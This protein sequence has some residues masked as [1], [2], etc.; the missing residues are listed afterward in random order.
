MIKLRR[1]S[2]LIFGSFLVWSNAYA[3]SSVLNLL[4]ITPSAESV[5]YVNNKKQFHLYSLITEQRN[6]KTYN[7]SYQISQ[8][9][10]AGLQSLLS[11]DKDITDKFNQ[12]SADPE[13]L[14]ILEQ[15]SQAVQNAIL[16]GHKIYFYGTGSTGRLAEAVESVLWR[17]FWEKVAQKPEWNKLK[18]RLPNIQN[19]LKGEIT[20]ADRALI[21]SLEGFED[22]Q[23]IGKLQ[24]ADNKM[25]KDDVIFAVTEGGETSAVIGTILAAASM[26]DHQPTHNLYFVY[27]NPERVLRP[28]DRS[29]SVLDNPLI[30]KINVTTGPQALSGS[31]RMQATTSSLYLSGVILEDAIY[32][33]LQRY[34]SK[35]ELEQLDFNQ[36]M[37][38][39][40]QLRKFAS[41]QTTVYDSAAKIT[42]WTNLEADTYAKQHHVTYFAQKALLPVFI[43]VTERPPTFRLPPLDQVNA[44]EKKSWISVWSPAENKQ[45]AWDMLLHRPFHGLNPELYQNQF[46]HIEDPYLKKIALKS[47]T[48]AGE[49]QK[50]LYDLSFSK[51]NIEN[52]GPMAGDLGVM[53]LLSHE[54][55][56]SRFWEWLKLF[57]NAKANLV[58]VSVAQTPLPEAQIEEFK[59]LKT[60]T[61]YLQIIIPHDDPFGLSQVI[62]LKMLLNA[63]STGVM[64]KLGRVVGNTMTDVQPSNLK[65]VGRATYL[66]QTHVNAVLRSQAWIKSYGKNPPITFADANAVLFD[67]IAYVNNAGLTNKFSEVPLAIV[68][69][70]E[71]LKQHKNISWEQARA[72]L[73][74]QKL[75]EYLRTV[76]GIN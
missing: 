4:E 68:R 10:T 56:T 8:N 62:A 40:N 27:N 28:F 19:R 73:E 21:S 2:K 66:I 54:N 34:L 46:N 61:N 65:L 47:L 72:I 50:N 43:D 38:I 76:Q 36:S 25:Q 30:T 59:K 57:A 24:L 42:P 41:I 35:S 70:L 49:E 67:A 12:M 20:G 17:P 48:N 6:P 63:N 31:T 22:L 37:T 51:E 64:A 33:V 44:K 55:L 1:I 18:D 3:N 7:L 74:H 15:A 45:Q 29:R 69:I 60:T 16:N 5:D 13:Q 39:Q 26:Y 75:G 58:L 9:T 53:I 23:I 52:N 11:V 71:S 32:H 14:K